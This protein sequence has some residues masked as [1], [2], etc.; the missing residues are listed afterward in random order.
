M[1]AFCT[2]CG[3]EVNAE[4]LYCNWCGKPRSLVACATPPAAQPSSGPSAPFVA[5]VIILF[6]VGCVIVYSVLGTSHAAA[7][8][9]IDS[10]VD[11]CGT[12]NRAVL[13]EKIVAAEDVIRDL[14]AEDQGTYSAKLHNRLKF[15][16]CE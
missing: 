6:L 15:I 4:G 8:R 16:M 11:A 12:G 13:A 3:K 14:P 7:D 2:Q 9:A 1:A 5:I 10:A